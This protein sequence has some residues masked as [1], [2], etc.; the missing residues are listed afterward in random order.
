MQ[1]I[2]QEE[3]LSLGDAG[4]VVE[5]KPGYARNFLLPQNKAVAANPKNLEMFAHQKKMAAARQAKLKAAAE[6]LKAK[7][8]GTAIS[9]ARTV[10]ENDKLFGSVTSK[11]ISAEL[12]AAGLELDRRRIQLADPLK[13]L[14]EVEVSIKLHP[15]VIAKLKVT[16]AKA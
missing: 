7:V 2:L 10:G 12:K 16:V 8:E 13:E 6:E 4:D 14:G 1:V 11:D 3:V 9:I 5:V 15:E